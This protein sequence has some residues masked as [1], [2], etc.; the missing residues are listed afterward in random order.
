V[1]LAAHDFGGERVTWKGPTGSA[2]EMSGVLSIFSSCDF[3]NIVSG[4]DCFQQACIIP[5]P[6]PWKYGK[7]ADNG[8]TSRGFEPLSS[9]DDKS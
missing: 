8:I 4:V 6:T 9:D 2:S 3:G 5:A 1:R 7:A